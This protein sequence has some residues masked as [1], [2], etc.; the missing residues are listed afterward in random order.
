MLTNNIESNQQNFLQLENEVS[1]GRAFQL[2]SEDPTASILG[3]QLQEQI[4]RKTQ[5]QSNLTTD[6]SY[7]SQTDTELTTRCQSGLSSIQSTVQTAVGITSTAA[8]RAAAAQQVQNALQQLVAIGNTQYQ[9][10]YLFAGSNSTVQP[11]QTVG[12]NVQYNGNTGSL[13]AY[14]DTNQLLGTNVDGNSAF[15]TISAPVQ[16]LQFDTHRDARHSVG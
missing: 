8:D 11:F 2:P 1:T 14:V 12:N 6:Q 3:L 15:G 16:G 9:G 5:I 13:N 7:L 10:R 4:A